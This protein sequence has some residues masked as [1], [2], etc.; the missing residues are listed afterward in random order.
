[1]WSHSCRISSPN[2]SAIRA[3]N[4]APNGSILSTTLLDQ[5]QQLYAQTKAISGT[6]PVSQWATDTYAVQAKNGS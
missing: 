6:L 1:M 3:A 5:Q 4:W 2:S